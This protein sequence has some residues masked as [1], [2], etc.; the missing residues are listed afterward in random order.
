MVVD[1]FEDSAQQKAISRCTAAQQAH[2]LL[3]SLRRGQAR[4]AVT[5]SAAQPIQARTLQTAQQS[6]CMALYRGRRTGEQ[7]LQMGDEEFRLKTNR[8]PLVDT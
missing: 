7:I 2:E 8:I 4:E 1:Q 3:F 5:D 6:G